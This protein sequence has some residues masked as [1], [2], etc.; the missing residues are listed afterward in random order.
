[1]LM[2]PDLALK[3]VGW[4]V[5]LIQRAQ[6]FGGSSH[7]VPVY[8]ALREMETPQ[9][10][11]GQKERAFPPFRIAGFRGSGVAPRRP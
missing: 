5:R 1:M 6:L 10:R 8:N 7:T 3:C 2:L 4:V 11:L 9:D